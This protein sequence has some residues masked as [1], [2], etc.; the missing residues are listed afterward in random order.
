MALKN[1]ILLDT[2]PTYN[3]GFNS[4]T[5]VNII[6]LGINGGGESVVQP[7][8]L[9]DYIP[10]YTYGPPLDANSYL[11]ATFINATDAMTIPTT[12][13]VAFGNYA[14]AVNK[15]LYI[16]GRQ[17]LVN[18]FNTCLTTGTLNLQGTFARD[19]GSILSQDDWT[20]QMSL[21]DTE[22]WA[23]G[24]GTVAFE[25]IMAGSSFDI[26]NFDMDE[27]YVIRA[28]IHPDL[29]PPV[30]PI[31]LPSSAQFLPENTYYIDCP[32]SLETGR[33]DGNL[34]ISPHGLLAV[35]GI[36]LLALKVVATHLPNGPKFQLSKLR[37]TNSNVFQS[38]TSG[39]LTIT[40][41]DG[42]G[43]T[44]KQARLIKFGKI[45]I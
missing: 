45:Q 32:V 38:V 20:N 33:F 43:L 31:A 3:N 10:E 37:F 18:H 28:I 9:G 23:N 35:P 19:D 26:N 6:L 12:A 27:V 17:S 44:K 16:D 14:S 42:N 5:S 34:M 25:F 29:R 41:E 2:T 40:D 8:N 4:T 30:E 39:R 21:E 24:S 15:I 13:A 11:G 7:S 1:H 22:G 36:Q